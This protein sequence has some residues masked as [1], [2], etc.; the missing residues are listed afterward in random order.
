MYRR[1]LVAVDGSD[2]SG[3]ALHEAIGLARD[4]RAGLRIVYAIDAVNV[5]AG[6]EFSTP[7]DMEAW[8][9]EAGREI[10]DQARK[11]AEE[12][13][14]GAETR[15]IEIDK[16]GLGIPGAIIEEAKTWPADLVV[17]GTHGRT[18]LGHLLMGSVAEGIVRGSPVPVLL[19]RRTPG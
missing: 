3:R 2:T 16:L 1:I 13:G 9:A 18:G 15:L 14:V 11:Q 17:A 7:P 5:N 8:W 10:L 19:V 12:A 6:A 4:Q